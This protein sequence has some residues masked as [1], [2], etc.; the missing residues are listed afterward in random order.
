MKKQLLYIVIISVLIQ[1]I[2]ITN[3]FS[4]SFIWIGTNSSSWLVSGNWSGGGSG[5]T[6]G[7]GDNIT[8][9]SNAPNNLVLDQNRTVANFTIN[10]DTVDLGTYTLTTAGVTYFN[11]GLVSTG[12]LNI[13]G[14][15]C[16][17]GGA[18]INARTEAYCGY[19]HMNGGTFLKPVLLIS[20]GSASTSGTGNCNFSDSLTINHSGVYYFTMSSTYGD[21]FSGPVTIVNNATHELYL[22]S[23]DTSYFENNLIISNT[24]TGGVVF[25]NTGGVTYLASGKT[26]SIGSS[27][28][29]NNYLTLKNFYQLGTTAQTL[30]LTGTAIVNFNNAHFDGNLTVTSPGILLKNSTFIGTTTLTRNGSSGNFHSDGGNVFAELSYTNSGTAGRVRMASTTPDTYLGN[31]TFGSSGQDFQVAYSGENFFHGNVTIT[32]NKVVFNTAIGKVTFSGGNS[33]SLNGSYNY[34]FK[35]LAIN[36]S[37][38]HVTANTTLSVDDTLFFVSKNLITTSTNLLTMKA[39]SVASGASNSSFV[40]GPVKK[41]GSTGF[42]YPVGKGNYF[43]MMAISAPTNATDAYTAEYF[44]T[45]QTFS[46]TTDTTI[47]YL[48]D[49]N[50]WSLNRVTGSS[51]VYVTLSWDSAYCHIF[52]R[53]MDINVMNLQS[54][55]WVKMGQKDLSGDYAYGTVKTDTTINSFGYF[56]WGFER[57]AD[58]S[59]CNYNPSLVAC[60]MELI[61]NGGFEQGSA[62]TS[63]PTW[64]PTGCFNN[65]GPNTSQITNWEIPWSGTSD[66]IIRNNNFNGIP[67]NWLTTCIGGLD[68]WAA[69]NNDRYAGMVLSEGLLTNLV[70]PLVPGINYTLSFYSVLDA[71]P[72]GQPVSP[73]PADF[74]FYAVPN[75]PYSG[76]AE[77]LLGTVTITSTTAG[78]PQWNFY[79]FNFLFNPTSI[80]SPY[81]NLVLR[82]NTAGPN[83]E[84]PYFFIDDVSLTTTSFATF[85]NTPPCI[86]TPTNFTC[87]FNDPST[88]VTYL[89]NFG[90]GN[91]ANTQNPSNI[92]TIPGYYEVVLT[93]NTPTC[94]DCFRKVIFVSPS[95]CAVNSGVVTYLNSTQV[96][97]HITSNI[98]WDDTMFGVGTFK[99]NRTITV[100]PDV[101]LTIDAGSIIEFGPEGRIILDRRGPTNS[102]G[103]RMIMEDNSVLTSISNSVSGCPVMWQG[104]EVWGHATIDQNS[105]ANRD[106]HAMLTMLGETKIENAHNGVILGRTA[107]PFGNSCAPPS[108][109]PAFPPY[110]VDF[111]GGILIAD[112]SGNVFEKNGIG[113]RILPYR[114]ANL[115]S[116]INGVNFI[117]GTLLDIFYNSNTA[118]PYTLNNNPNRT[119]WYGEANS[120][121]R[122]CRGIWVWG[123]NKMWEFEN[124][125]MGDIDKGI[126]SF[127]SNIRTISNNFTNHRFGIDVF[128]TFSYSFR[129]TQHHGNTFSD[130]N[131]GLSG[132]SPCAFMTTN[133]GIRLNAGW[134]DRIWDINEFGDIKLPYVLH[135]QPYDFNGILVWGS[136]NTSIKDNNFGQAA[137]GILMGG[138]SNTAGFIGYA[139]F[140]NSF[141]ENKIGIG[142]FSNNQTLRIRCNYWHTSDI[143]CTDPGFKPTCWLHGGAGTLPA[144]QGQSGP[145]AKKPAGNEFN[146]FSINSPLK[147]IGSGYPYVYHHHNQSNG[148]STIPYIGSSN[149]TLSDNL[150]GKT[151]AS[152]PSF[153][154]NNNEMRVAIDSLEIIRD[155]LTAI[156]TELIA[157]LDGGNTEDLLRIINDTILSE[158]NITDSLIINSPLSDVVLTELILRMDSID[159]RN[160]EL[161]MNKNLPVSNDVYPYFQNFISNFNDTN[162]YNSLL[163]RQG[164]NSG[165][166]TVFGIEREIESNKIESYSIIY[167][168]LDY[169]SDNDS[170]SEYVALLASEDNIYFKMNLIGTLLHFEQNSTVYE[171]LDAIT[172]SSESYLDWKNII[173]MLTNLSDSGKTVFSMDSTMKSMV[174]QIANKNEPTMAVLNAISIMT[175]VYGKE[176]NNFNFDTDSELSRMTSNQDITN[177][178]KSQLVNYKIYP[179]PAKNRIFI[180]IIEKVNL[181]L[182]LI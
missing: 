43:R 182:N 33:Q 62:I 24:S 175:L 50:Y 22:A 27:G 124:N 84:V 28:F 72:F 169:Y 149:I 101:T 65:F 37:A 144:Q 97:D 119:P 67:L 76:P 48:S 104:V 163:S 102:T 92:Y 3:S 75:L 46:D 143:I 170:I 122:A 23:G 142:S 159:E 41:I 9:N 36:K 120:F 110:L 127:D 30:T 85:T 155:S 112:N 161:I 11:G 160:F 166:F 25:G 156:K 158:V 82:P 81:E 123:N 162:I 61:C 40:S 98:T 7:S 44:Y 121:G 157:I 126:E 125:T 86:G 118:N 165:T 80:L 83:F 93:V 5:A 1:T 153:S 105:N 58:L 38:N 79:T 57:L 132:S 53:Y 91:T 47:E 107:F 117:G 177:F 116:R 95:C 68:T 34:S 74:G 19:F 179:N 134:N 178:P 113:I 15:L 31:V 114:F 49:C 73:Y 42:Q 181:V 56:T 129:A 130:I 106:A 90:D 39:G 6:P 96:P 138:T 51:K 147:I 14:S 108:T 16:H 32:S 17:F 55:N 145:N 8:I 29:T 94:S 174:M 128:N 54:T 18:T 12:N 154:L 35:K 176:Y 10:G 168:L 59:V 146:L 109:D 115:T 164:Y 152:C 52:N 150:I 136:D 71:C 148:Q 131:L 133:A 13:S 66:I 21:Q 139:S 4:A 103:A 78:S 135:T 77:E 64:L 180:E 20:T 45:G 137:I 26:I 172:D 60:Q 70:A 173:L 87:F 111:G 88:I 141:I 2:F 63:D 100:D 99:L 171:L 89:W 151:S 167:D 140:G 69:T